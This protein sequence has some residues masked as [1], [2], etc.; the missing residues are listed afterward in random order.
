MDSKIADF[1]YIQNASQ[2][3]RSPQTKVTTPQAFVLTPLP[4]IILIIICGTKRDMTPRMISHHPRRVTKTGR[5]IIHMLY[6]LTI[7]KPS[8]KLIIAQQ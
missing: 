4:I 3:R 1:N 2:Q 6:W 7:A 8:S 5:A